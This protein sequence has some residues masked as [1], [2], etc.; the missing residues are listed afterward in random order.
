LRSALIG[1]SNEDGREPRLAGRS[2][3]AHQLA[4][5]LAWGAE[6][7]VLC[8]DGASPDAVDLR[9]QA[10]KGGAKFQAVRNGHALA[11]LVDEDDLLLVMQPGLVAEPVTVS[12]GDDPEVLAFPAGPGIAAG[13][14]RI[15]LARAWAGIALLPGRLVV[16]LERLPEESSPHSALL[17]IALQAHVPMRDLPASLLSDHA[18][19]VLARGEK[20]A[21]QEAAWIARQSP[22]ARRWSLSEKLAALGGKLAAPRLLDGRRS[23]PATLAGALALM[24]LS[25]PVAAFGLPTVAFAMLVLAVPLL[26]LAMRVGV[27]GNR[28]PANARWPQALPLSADLALF[29]CG[30]LALEG[31]WAWRIFLPLIVV[32]L[33]HVA[34]PQARDGWPALATDRMALAALLVLAVVFGSLPQALMAIAVLLLSLHLAYRREHGG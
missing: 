32:G 30:M 20:G 1:F 8:G 18:W 34:E 10:E 24:A 28:V 27:L 19:L 23:F 22:P 2:A 4:I 21:A 3:A 12:P 9:R 14:E 25:V 13:L 16:R 33:L 31:S 6:Q 11:G 7:V 29:L 17:R 15:D 26:L 5:A